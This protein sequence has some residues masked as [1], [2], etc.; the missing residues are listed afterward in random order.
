M[1]D[2]SGNYSVSHSYSQ[3]ALGAGFDSV[4]KDAT[5]SGGMYQNGTY[6][7]LYDAFNRRRAKT[8]P[9]S[10]SDEYFHDLGHQLLSDRGVDVIGSS[11]NALPED[12]YIWLGGRPVVIVRGQFNASFARL[13]DGYNSCPRNGVTNRCS[14]NFPVTDYLGKPVLM[15]SKASPSGYGGTAGMARY[16]MFGAA[17]RREARYASP[18]STAGTHTVMTIND[19]MPP[20]FDG[21]ARVLFNK[22]QYGSGCTIQVNG[23]T[24]PLGLAAPPPSLAGS[25]RAHAWSNWEYR[26][27]TGWAVAFVNAAIFPTINYGFDMEAYEVK[28]KQY[29]IA[30]FWTPLRFPGQYY[31]EETELHENWNRYY[32]PT[33]GRY[34]Q[35]EPLLDSP[36]FLTRVAQAGYATPSYAYALNNPVQY[37]DADGRCPMCAVALYLA[38]EGSSIGVGGAV[39]LGVGAAATGAGVGLITSGVRGTGYDGAQGGSG[40]TGPIDQ[41]AG[42]AGGHTAGPTTVRPIAGD[43]APPVVEARRNPT[44][45]DRLEQCRARC[46]DGNDLHEWCDTLPCDTPQARERLR[47]CRVAGDQALT[48]QV[49]ECMGTCANA[50]GG[51]QR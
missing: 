43:R 18:H 47:L 11:P 31:D 50:F 23:V 21:W 19:D 8:T 17:N 39:A 5:L 22:T 4:F 37:S 20:G 13:P 14:T 44:G 51:N 46:E 40:H 3:S 9:W 26:T 30:E 15:L 25:P 6:G 32:D 24:Q 16:Q 10:T 12:D 48:G 2:V 42:G 28:M 35:P 38:I 36:Q 7:Y 1:A 27:S 41:G 49:S 29:D 45:R 34:L 33:T